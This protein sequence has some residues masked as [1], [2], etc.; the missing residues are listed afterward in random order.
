[1]NESLLQEIALVT[2]GLY[3]RASGA[4]FGLDIIYSREISKFEKTEFDSKM[5]RRYFERFQW[6]LSVAVILLILETFLSVR[7]KKD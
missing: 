4:K 6:P 1:L 2:G 5:K 7:R 3:V